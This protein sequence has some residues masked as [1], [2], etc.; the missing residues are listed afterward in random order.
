MVQ[1]NELL[2]TEQMHTKLASKETENQSH[3]TINWDLVNHTDQLS[4]LFKRLFLDG[5]KNLSWFA[6]QINESL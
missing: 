6:T 1:K 2:G 5:F 3:K 4:R